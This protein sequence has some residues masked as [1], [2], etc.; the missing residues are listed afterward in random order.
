M[1]LEDKMIGGAHVRRTF[2]RGDK[3]LYA[4]DTLTR[5]EVLDIRPANRRALV[6]SNFIEIWPLPADGERYAFHTGG[7]DWSVVEGRKINESPLSK[8][9]ALALAAE[10]TH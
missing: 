6:D 10:N 9:E 5:D 1:I 8:E 7:G 4:G 3:R 2:T